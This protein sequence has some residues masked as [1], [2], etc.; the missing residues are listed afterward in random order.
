[1]LLQKVVGAESSA[2]LWGTRVDLWRRNPLVGCTGQCLS[3][4]EK[5]EEGWSLGSSLGSILMCLA[6]KFLHNHLLLAAVRARSQH[7]NW[8][9]LWLYPT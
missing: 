4:W 6:V 2:M 8:L 7:W 9:D 1:M 5:P 3:A